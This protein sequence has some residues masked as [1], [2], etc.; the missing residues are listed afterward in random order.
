VL[1]SILK[2]LALVKS[3]NNISFNHFNVAQGYHP[4][5]G[6]ARTHIMLSYGI[7][8]KVQNCSEICGVFKLK[9]TSL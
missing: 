3:K 5:K 2:F 6:L 9:I 4:L 7:E 8:Y 1:S